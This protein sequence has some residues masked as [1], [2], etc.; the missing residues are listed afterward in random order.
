MEIRT[1][2]QE[3]HLH[4][5][6]V[7]SGVKNCSRKPQT[8]V[9]CGAASSCHR[10]AFTGLTQGGCVCLCFSVCI[11]FILLCHVSGEPTGVFQQTLHQCSSTNDRIPFLSVEHD[12]KCWQTEQ[13]CWATLR[14]PMFC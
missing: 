11:S 10:R 1:Y 2:Q 3:T 12:S 8:T 7:S 14:K 6:P 4:L 13:P 9:L 5:C